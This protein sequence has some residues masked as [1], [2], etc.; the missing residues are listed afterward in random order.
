MT[1]WAVV[2]SVPAIAEVFPPE[3]APGSEGPSSVA[4]IKAVLFCGQHMGS[5]RSPS[6]GCSW[7]GQTV[8]EVLAC[9]CLTYKTIVT[10]T[11]P[12]PR[13]ELRISNEFP[14][15]SYVGRIDWAPPHCW[16]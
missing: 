16:P 1:G 6:P 11:N 8:R 10:V 13:S 9:C 12:S 4:A 3:I 2:H 14:S 7:Y 15:L 5:K